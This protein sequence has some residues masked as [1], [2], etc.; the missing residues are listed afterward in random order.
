MKTCLI[1]GLLFLSLSA[2]AAEY[3]ISLQMPET[4]AKAALKILGKDITS[5]MEITKTTET[6]LYWS[7]K[8]YQTYLELRYTGGKVSHIT[9]WE[10]KDFEKNKSHRADSEL[11][12]SRVTFDTDKLSCKPTR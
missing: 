5:G 1:L 9:Y 4:D 6:G 3:Q 11:S 12:V 7:F 8:E 10:A 2:G